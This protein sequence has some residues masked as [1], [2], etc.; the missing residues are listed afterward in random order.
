MAQEATANERKKF[1][2]QRVNRE[3]MADLDGK[4][5]MFKFPP[6]FAICI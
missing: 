3:A 4:D 2:V 5:I 1:K 6:T